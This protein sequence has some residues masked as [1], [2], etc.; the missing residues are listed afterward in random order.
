[1][2]KLMDLIKSGEKIEAIKLFREMT[3]A[4]LKDAKDTIDGLEL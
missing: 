3:G 4:S 1:M 2:S